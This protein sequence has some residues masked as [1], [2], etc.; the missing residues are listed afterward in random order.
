MS[1][2]GDSFRIIPVICEHFAARQEPVCLGAEL[3]VHR[4]NLSAKLLKEFSKLTLFMV[5]EW[6]E[7]PPEHRYRQSGDSC[8][9]LT[10]AKQNEH[11]EAAM[12]AVGYPSHRV[13]IMRMS[14]TDAAAEV[15][16]APVFFDFVF[17]DAD[18]TYNGTITDMQCWWPLVR[19]GGLLSGHDFDHPKEKRNGSFG[20]RKAVE[21]FCRD[22]QLK[23]SLS[24]SCWWIVKP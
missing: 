15:F 5:D 24:G 17:V 11:M 16:S 22:N 21:E 4:G 12:R 18:H 20:V 7:Y 2:M 14:T 3:G 10:L 19:S 23:F 8:G 13:M 6:R 9:N 1:G